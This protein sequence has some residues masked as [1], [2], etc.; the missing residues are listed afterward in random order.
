MTAWTRRPSRSTFA[1]DLDDD[2]DVD[3]VSAYGSNVEWYENDGAADPSFTTRTVNSTL[4]FASSVWGADL[5][6]DGDGDLL[7][8]S[9]FDNTVAWY[10]N[11][12]MDP[13]AFTKRV[14]DNAA[15]RPTDVI[16]RDMDGDT[17]IDVVMTSENGD[18]IDWY[19]SDGAT[20]PTFA[21]GFKVTTDINGPQA[22]V[23]SDLDGDLDPDLAAV[24]LNDGKVAW[25]EF[26]TPGFGACCLPD[27]TCVDAQCLA[28]CAAA[29]GWAWEVDATCDTITCPGGEATAA[30]LVDEL[31]RDG[32]V[33]NITFLAEYGTRYWDRPQNEEATLWLAEQLESYGY[34]NVVLDPY[35]F[36]GKT[37]H[38][39]YATKMGTERPTEMYILG[40]HFDTFNSTGQF[41]DAPGADDDGSGTAS[42]LELA[43]VFAN[44]QTDVSVRFVLW[45]NEETG[46]NGSSAYVENHKNLQGTLE[47]PTWLGMIQQDMIMW[48]YGP[49]KTPDAD[50]EYQAT[51]DAEG[52]AIIL[53]S[54]VAGAMDRYGDLPAQLSGN[55]R[56]TDSVPFMTE[57]VAISVRE[58][59]RDEIGD[60][61]NPHW[62]RPTDNMSTYGDRDIDHG[63]NICKMIAGA[64]GELVGARPAACDPDINDDGVVDTEDLLAILTAWGP[65]EGCPE[66]ID[67]SGTVDTAD[68]LAVLAGWG[69][70]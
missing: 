62:H 47:E 66:D 3:V 42:V 57:T 63:F 23:A 11:D 65:C 22:V 10:E 12:G 26:Q 2:T 29:L 25:Y 20:P 69:S 5:D 37:K 30:F 44:V 61:S 43:R 15:N 70:C 50:V 48:D 33:A 56:N 13:P 4:V 52:F 6:D 21:G 1:F 18:K 24:G 60:G 19:Q 34:D 16:A 38:N 27:G 51:A 39:V 53:G 40:A 59:T 9:L 8:T 35:E 36:G 64:V 41:D 55:M 17:L 68:L 45:N 54:F 32:F 31:S 46:L 67:E 58:N 49:G 14:I 28:D 7:S